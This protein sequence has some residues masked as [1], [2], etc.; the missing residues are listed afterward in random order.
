MDGCLELANRSKFTNCNFIV[1]DNFYTSELVFDAHV[2]LFGVNGI[3]FT[4]C[5]FTYDIP[6]LQSDTCYG[7]DAFNSGF[8]VQPKCSLDP[9]IGEI[10]NSSNIE[11]AS[12]FTGFDFG[13]KAQNGDGFFKVSV[14]STNFDSNDYGIYLSGVNNAKILKNR[15]IIGKDNNLV[16]NPVGLYIQNGSGYRI[17]EN[18]FENNFVSNSEKIG[19]NIKNS[20]TENNQVY[21]NQFN[22][23]TYGQI[24]DGRNCTF[25]RPYKGLVSLCNKNIDNIGTL[26]T[27]LTELMFIPLNQIN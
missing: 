10:C 14:L 11:F 18:Q 21:K 23:L 3:S 7:I 25:T 13:I 16:L 5:R 6:S 4:G 12:S 19:L 15:F 2:K 20:G 24:F 8:T 27:Y 1:N 26:K 22:N 17:E 9:F